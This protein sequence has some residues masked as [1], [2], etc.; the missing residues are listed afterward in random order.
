MECKRE[1]NLARCNCTSEGCERRGICCDCLA[2]HLACRTFPACC[3]R[4][5]ED[6][7]GGRSF[8]RFAELVQTGRL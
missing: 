1:A 5:V 7:G 6:D 4:S 8:D 2:S 3:F